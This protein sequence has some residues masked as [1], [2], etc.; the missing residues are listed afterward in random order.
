MT[1]WVVGS[2][3]FDITLARVKVDYIERWEG[4]SEIWHGKQG[5]KVGR[6]LSLSTFSSSWSSSSAIAHTR[7]TLHGAQTIGQCHLCLICLQSV[8]VNWR[9]WQFSSFS[10]SLIHMAVSHSKPTQHYCLPVFSP[11]CFPEGRPACQSGRE[12][13]SPASRRW[14]H[15]NNILHIL[16]LPQLGCY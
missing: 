3:K 9:G 10:V 7:Y 4:H 5:W 16:Y 2:L 11:S 14:F 13:W 6:S 12:G 8:T 15:H 1:K